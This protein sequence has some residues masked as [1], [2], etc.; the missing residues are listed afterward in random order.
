MLTLSHW[1]T[2]GVTGVAVIACVTL[3]Y[4]CQ[5]FMTST[6][7]IAGLTFITWS[8][9]YTFIEMLKIWGDDK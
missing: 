4:E 7:A 6:E 5:R 8:A 3:H 9:S 2:V 1:I